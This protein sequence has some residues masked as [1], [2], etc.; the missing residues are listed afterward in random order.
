[1]V[2]FANIL[3]S[4]SCNLRCPHCVRRLLAQGEGQNNLDC[5]PLAGLDDFCVALRGAGVT[6]VALT[7]TNTDPLLYQHHG[8][9]LAHLRD[10]VPG[11]R[12]SLHTN[13]V[14]ALA[15]MEI[16]NSYDRVSVSRRSFCAATCRNGAGATAAQ[17]RAALKDLLAPP[18][19]DYIRRHRLYQNS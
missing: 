9:L 15:K 13:G 6:Q 12:I 5:F 11:A 19:M 8:L 2:D 14:L 17:W 10:Q 7:G 3:L 16:V 1:M 4:G 18:M